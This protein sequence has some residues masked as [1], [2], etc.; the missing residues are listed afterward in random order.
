MKKLTFGG[1]LIGLFPFLQF[2]EGS[3]EEYLKRL[4]NPQVCSNLVIYF[5]FFLNI[6]N[7]VF[8]IHYSVRLALQ[9]MEE[10]LL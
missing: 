9:C 4:E 10:F 6:L 3:F 5:C 7:N 8:Q 2:I 1:F